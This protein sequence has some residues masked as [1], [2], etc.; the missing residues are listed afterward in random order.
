MNSPILLSEDEFDRHYPLL[1]NH[2]DPHATWA[3]GDGPGCLFGLS[4]PEIQFVRAQ[5]PRTVWTLV[6]DDSGGT[7]LISGLHFVNRIGYLVSTVPLPASH[8]I[9]VHLETEPE[10]E[11]DNP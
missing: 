9:E 8:F 6:D 1:V 5:D 3:F 2:L 4:P 7:T 11:G 10:T